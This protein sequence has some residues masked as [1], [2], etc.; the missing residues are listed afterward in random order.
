MANI[1]LSQPYYA[2]YHNTNGV[3]SY[4][5]LKK[6]GKAINVDLAVDNKEPQ[7]LYANNGPAESV[8]L[9]GGGNVTLGIDELALD[10]AAD[11]LGMDA[12]T[13]QE[14]GVTFLADAQAPFIGQ[15]FIGMKVYEGVIKWRLVVLYKTQ[16]MLPDYAIDTKGETVS[17]QTPSLE[18]KIFRD[19]ASPSKWQYWNDYS[20]EADAIAALQA[21]LG[22]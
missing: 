5:G 7:I 19:D 20:T 22:T 3:V 4:T 13:E 1:G 10:V 21:K 14:P 15:G 12:P 17:F 16:F 6:L 9:F 11:V 2:M 18:A 8:T